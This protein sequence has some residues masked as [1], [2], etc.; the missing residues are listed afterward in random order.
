M[1]ETA[2]IA[3]VG[4]SLTADGDWQ[5]A[6]PD[7]RVENHGV[8]GDTTDGVIG[9]TESVLA[10]SPW[11]LVLLIGANDLAWHRSV[12]HIVRNIET[13]LATWRARLPGAQI[14]LQSVLP[15]EAEL[16]PEIREINRH[17]WQY[18]P[19]VRAQYLDLWPLLA[20]PDGVLD[21]SYSP[22]GLALSDAGYQAWLS[23]LRPAVDTLRGK[24][25]ASR[26]IILPKRMIG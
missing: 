2:L 5:S 25:P 22:D 23:E 9:R 7:D 15:R 24:P 11:L 19:C 18:A 1:S 20:T 13:I 26:A 16:A 3:F 12:E 8:A 4:D 17:L 21:P 14:L 10:N 6:F